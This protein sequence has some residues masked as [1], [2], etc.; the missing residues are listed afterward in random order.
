[1]KSKYPGWRTMTAS[2]RYNARYERIWS[3]ARRLSPEIFGLPPLSAD[4]KTIAEQK[5][6]RIG[7]DNEK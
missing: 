7:E 5:C 6:D 4:E 3:E 2:Q 1:M